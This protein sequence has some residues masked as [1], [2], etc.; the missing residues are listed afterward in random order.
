MINFAVRDI[1]DKSVGLG[2]S[3]ALSISKDK[4]PDV[5]PVVLA[6]L[7]DLDLAHAGVVGFDDEFGQLFAGRLERGFG[8]LACCRRALQSGSDVVE[9]GR[10]VAHDATSIGRFHWPRW[11]ATLLGTPD[12][13]SG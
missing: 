9:L 1:P 10:H 3:A 12:R 6:D 11:N 13:P 4:A 2:P 7:H 8:A 5:F